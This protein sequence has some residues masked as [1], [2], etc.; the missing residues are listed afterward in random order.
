MSMIDPLTRKTL[1]VYK[2]EGYDI[3]GDRKKLPALYIT[4]IDAE[5]ALAQA[6]M[7]HKGYCSMQRVD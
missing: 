4:A 7:I 3:G 2:V 6:R 1:H 5:S